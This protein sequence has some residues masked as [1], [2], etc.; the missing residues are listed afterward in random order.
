MM[1]GVRK[2]QKERGDEVK[3]TIEK[4]RVKAK[5]G[6]VLDVYAHLADQQAHRNGFR[7]MTNRHGPRDYFSVG[8]AP[9]YVRGPDGLYFVWNDGWEA[10]NMWRNGAESPQRDPAG[11]VWVEGVDGW[12]VKED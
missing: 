9:D 12:E 6:R 1:K 3:A 8:G 11:N 10:T 2:E 4:E 7:P 5:D